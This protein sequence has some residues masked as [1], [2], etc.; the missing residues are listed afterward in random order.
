MHVF[1][2]GATGFVGSAVVADLIAAGH[3]VT[4]LAR[5]DAGAAALAATGAAVH[6]GSLEDAADLAR[7]AGDSDGVIH[8]GFIHDFSR[9]AENCETDRRAITAMADALGPGDRPMVVTSGAALIR[10][11]DR[12]ATEEDRVVASPHAV[13]RVATELAVDEAVE[14][15][16]NVSVVRL[17]IVHD[18]G[19]HGFTPMLIDLARKTGR[20]GLA[21][22]GASRWPG[23]HRRDAAPVYRLALEAGVAG[24][25]YH[26]V[27]EEAV[28]QRDIGA[29]IARRLGLP[30]VELE[31]AE[32]E[33]HFDWFFHFATMDAP[34]ASR[35]TRE[36]L[37]WEPEGPGFIEDL[38]SP[39][40]FPA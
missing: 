35:L 20:V 31:P 30:L 32:A 7:A 33:A 40:Y 14:R 27:A 38:D 34:T 1:V 2:T 17:P 12:A 10:F 24:R 9:F 39:A 8:C 36:W 22:N 28:T 26:A 21:G 16:I 4:G 6:R 11:P 5:S 3:T 15:G 13:P 25:R 29:V 23:V 37:G 18:A 19:D